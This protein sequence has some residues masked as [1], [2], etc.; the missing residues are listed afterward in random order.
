MQYFFEP[1]SHS[2]SENTKSCVGFFSV[3]H[4]RVPDALV[5]HPDP[6]P[7]RGPHRQLVHLLHL[8]PLL[9]PLQHVQ[10]LPRLPLL[11]RLLQEQ[12]VL[13]GKIVTLK[14]KYRQRVI[15]SRIE[16]LSGFCARTF[17]FNTRTKTAKSAN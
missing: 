10:V 12:G 7:A 8:L 4:R 16:E 17:I 1:L 2:V 5:D 3:H 13:S 11:L 15:K 14:M 9:L 6:G